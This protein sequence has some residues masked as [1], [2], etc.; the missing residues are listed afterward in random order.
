MRSKILLSC[1]L[2]F[3]FLCANA[4]TISF[5][6]PNGIMKVSHD[7][8]KSWQQTK[9]NKVS[10]HYPYGISKQ[11]NDYGKTWT[12]SD[13]KEVTITYPDILTKSSVDKGKTW[14]VESSTSTERKSISTYP[15]PASEKAIVDVSKQSI[16]NETPELFTLAGSRIA[17]PKTSE[18]M[19]NGEYFLNT[20]S[21]NSG[22]YIIRF[23]TNDGPVSGKILVQH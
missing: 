11:S 23:Q 6:Y 15:N 2:A 9:I 12:T 20:S 22:Y 10:F 21:L 7:N 17:I 18:L 5:R 13:F 19:E 3:A 4:Q 1:V 8:G 16:L 14:T